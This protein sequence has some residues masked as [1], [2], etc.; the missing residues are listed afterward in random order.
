MA[1]K[2]PLASWLYSKKS[3]LSPEFQEFNW[4]A[5][6]FSG[7]FDFET[8]ITWRSIVAVGR[9]VDVNREI[10][11]EKSVSEAIERLICHELKFASVGFAVAGTHD[12]STHAQ[13]EALER[14]YLNRHIENK[15]NLCCLE[16]K[17]LDIDSFESFKRDYSVTFY[18]MQTEELFHGIV[19]RLS[20]R[21]EKSVSFGFALSQDQENSMRRAFF[22]ALPSFAWLIS[23]ENLLSQYLPWQIE[24]GFIAKLDALLE[25]D[26]QF[27][28]DAEKLKLTQI[29]VDISQIS[30]LSD[31]PLKLGKFAVEVEK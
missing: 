31:A 15:I 27:V 10:A 7:V 30:I 16:N 14:Y 22:E 9:G 4:P 2:T 12:P 25:Q 3:E 21:D 1:N 18:R 5:R 13:H 11:L 19:C 24:E 17:S 23:G 29:P 28:P 20:S 26:T 6:V 8:K